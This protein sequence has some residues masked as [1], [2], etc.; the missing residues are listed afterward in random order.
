MGILEMT[1]GKL[2]ASGTDNDLVDF[3]RKVGLAVDPV[4][5]SK[6]ITLD[7]SAGVIP[8]PA[9]GGIT[10]RGEGMPKP[11]T[12]G[13]TSLWEGKVNGQQGF[14]SNNGGEIP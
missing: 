14:C 13:I 3:L 4:V 10:S 9:T 5:D 11:V 2:L 1:A 7:I 6:Q 8:K 12:A